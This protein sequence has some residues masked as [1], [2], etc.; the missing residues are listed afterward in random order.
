MDDL[1]ADY[2]TLGVKAAG[3]TNRLLDGTREIDTTLLN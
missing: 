2:M 1:I 3:T